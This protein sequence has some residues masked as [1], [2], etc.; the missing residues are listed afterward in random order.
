[1]KRHRFANFWIDGTRSLV[2]NTSLPKAI[3]EEEK[4]RLREDLAATHGVINV[5]ERLERYL[6]FNPPN[7]YILTEFHEL[8]QQIQDSYISGYDYTALTGACCLDE[9]ILNLLIIKTRRYYTQ[10]KY[11]KRTYRKDSIQGWDLAIDSLSDWG[12]LKGDS[13]AK[14]K[15]LSK[16]RN[17]SVHYESLGDLRPRALASLSLVTAIT[18]DLLGLRSDVFFW[19]PGEP[20]IR[21]DMEEDPVVQEFFIP[22]CP[23]VGYKHYLEGTPKGFA[24]HDNFD[25]EPVEVNDDEFR[26]LREEWQNHHKNTG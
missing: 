16:L 12:I 1:M 13:I 2:N 21:K 11:Y 19:V 22:N 9:R 7:L 8:F 4:A 25:Y 17:A 15:G 10:S 6:E 3:V 24:I 18:D 26:R 20:Y 5:E 23:L 14:F